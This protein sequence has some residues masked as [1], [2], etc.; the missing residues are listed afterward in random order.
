LSAR[1]SI[2]VLK[3]ELKRIT[4]PALVARIRELLV[5]PYPVE[6]DWDYGRIGEKFTCWTVLEHP[7][8]STGIAYCPQGFGPSDPW[9]LIFLTG[10]HQG[11]GMDSGW[12]L[13][14][15]SAMRGS[16]AWDRPNPENYEVALQIGVFRCTALDGSLLFVTL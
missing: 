13:N 4:D 9:G 12:F 7:Q 5:L 10:G 15:E 11:I 14:L 16:M 6:R 3:Q 2:L 8:S 1:V